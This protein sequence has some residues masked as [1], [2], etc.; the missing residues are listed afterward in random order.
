MRAI[1]F[2]KVSE[3]SLL[4]YTQQPL[5]RFP[6]YVYAWFEPSRAVMEDLSRD[7]KLHMLEMANEDRWGLYYGVKVRAANPKQLDMILVPAS[8]EG[9]I[10]QSLAR[11]NAEARLFWSFLDETYG[12]DYLTFCL[13]CYNLAE[14]IAGA[15]LRSQWGGTTL[16]GSSYE[17][18][19]KA[20]AKEAAD[21]EAV[22][23]P[24]VTAEDKA[25]VE[26]RYSGGQETIWIELRHARAGMDIILAKASKVR[27]AT[28]LKPCCFADVV[29]CYRRHS[30]RSGTESRGLQSLAKTGS[31]LFPGT[32][33]TRSVSS[34]TSGS[35]E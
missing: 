21:V 1:I 11:E 15:S 35:S 16:K 17:I 9:S 12:M 3:L 27:T 10:G 22:A 14:N 24:V 26:D 18:L 4:G 23:I 13:Y 30:T 34:S 6:D 2:S 20:L 25:P 29:A 33:R 31:L 5:S 7:D 28:P 32:P 19:Q 8:H